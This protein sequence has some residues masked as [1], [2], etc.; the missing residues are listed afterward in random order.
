MMKSSELRRVFLDFFRA[1]GHTIVPSDTLVP[2]DDQTLLFTSA[3]MNQ[4]KDQFIGKDITY[5]R[6]ASCQKCLRTGDLDNVGRTSGHHTFFE[7]LGNFSFGDYF[8]KEACLWAWEFMTSALGIPAERLWISV[9]RDDN[10]AYDIWRSHVSIPDSKIV[11][12][13]ARDNFWPSNAPTEGPN[14]P[15]GPCSEIFYDW[16]PASGCGRDG[17]SPACDCGRF[18]EVWNLVFTGYNRVGPD[19]LEPLP[20][21]NIDTGMGLERITAVMQGVRTNFETD[22]FA[23]VTSEI[24]SLCPGLGTFAV[25]AIADHLR[26][27]V[28]AVC[29]G[30]SPSNEERG[31]VVRKLIRRAYLL[32]RTDGPFLY[33]LT[34]KVAGVMGD[35]YPVLVNRRDDIASVILEEE[36]RFRGTLMTAVPKL[37]DII[38]ACRKERVIPGDEM[39]RLVDTFGLPLEVIE[40]HAKRAG[41]KMDTVGYERLMN[42]RRELSRKGSKIK[43]SIFSADAFA[44]APRPPAKD[45]MPLEAAIAFMATGETVIEA[46]GDGERVFI[47][48]DPQ[49]GAF[50]G[51]AGGQVGDTGDLRGKRAS[52]SIVNTR[53]ADGRIIH[54]CVI[55]RGPA[56]VGD[57]VTV[58]MD[59]G[60]KGAIARNH[61]A[62]HLLHSALRG[63]L[64]AHVH[65]CGSLV[66]DS[67]LRFDFTHAKKVS[68]EEIRKIEDF[69]NDRIREAADV[70]TE[71]KNRAAAEKEGAMALFGEKYADDVRVVTVTGCSKEL[72]GGTHVR[73]TREIGLFKIVSEGSIASGIRRI[74]A[75]TSDRVKDWLVKDMEDLI[76]AC[77]AGRESVEGRVGPDITAQLPGFI[78]DLDVL[79]AKAVIVCPDVREYAYEIRPRVLGIIDNFGKLKKK[80]K[81]EEANR[82]G[83]G[84]GDRVS[85]LAER[86]EKCKDADV[87]VGVIEN[88][89]MKALRT[90]CDDLRRKTGPVFIALAS[91]SQDKVSMV[92]AVTADLAEKGVDAASIIRES[93]SHIGGSGGGRKDFA[94]AGGKDAAGMRAALD[95]ARQIFK[96]RYGSV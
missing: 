44:G 9:Y 71:I 83:M 11:K 20:S 23:P 45:E 64:G 31:Y 34:A 79:K 10:E 78:R 48:T 56:T 32:G 39:F 92:V 25:N 15:C 74:E 90:A 66:E 8:K 93:V 57:T 28:F 94:Q 40:E 54:E 62:T 49:C 17:C 67:R 75:V 41:Y 22:L 77:N 73:N 53:K 19:K 29:D 76:K 35:A 81:K 6:A 27:S 3:G 1:K 69:V 4:F 70:R 50:Y 13:D 87:I 82:Q 89:D 14:G 86:A 24:K 7:M 33:K 43:E 46:A 58:R 36:E 30:V 95:K 96:N 16:G 37:K 65:Q 47:V 85:A 61:T 21:K 5:R 2:R 68:D 18:I 52:A 42:E 60:R 84:L 12:L 26:A 51:E 38:S 88:A 63:L 91:A 55:T 59:S 72:C 80:L